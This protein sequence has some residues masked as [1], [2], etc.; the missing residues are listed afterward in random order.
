MPYATVEH[1]PTSPAELAAALQTPANFGAGLPD[2]DDPNLDDAE[3]QQQIDQAWQ[4][5]DRLDLQTD[6]WRGRILRTVRD[7]QKRSGDGRGSGFLQWLQAREITKS[8]AYHLIQLADSADTMIA[9]CDLEPAA[10][11]N[12]SKRAFLETAKAAPEIQK[13]VSQAAQSGDRITRREVKQLSDQWLAMSSDLL[14]APIRARAADGQLPARHL[15][16]LVRELEKLPA[17]H[18]DAIQQEITAHP[19]PDTAKMLTSEARNLSRYLEAAARVQSLQRGAVDVELALEEALRLDCLNTTA[20]LVRQATTLE[21]L[22]AKLYTTWLRL[23]QLS[24]RLYVETGASNPCLRSLLNSLEPLIGD[25]LEVQLDE[26][27]E[28]WVRLRWLHSDASP[29]A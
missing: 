28:H 11:D 20:E 29:S 4:T 6:I 21:Q 1:P 15:A 18:L 3:F 23:N 8:R 10:I 27:G 24:D 22:V 16:P 7:R 5:C 12:F 14:P 13:L 17:S 2:P 9:E 26:A 25:T 19:D